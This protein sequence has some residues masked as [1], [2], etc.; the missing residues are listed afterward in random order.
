MAFRVF[1][2]ANILLDFLLKRPEYDPARQLIAWAVEGRIAAFIS[3]SVVHITG[4]W[5]TKVYKSDKAKELL[6]SLLADIRVI[7]IGHVTTINALFSKMV[8]LEDAMQYY[9]AIQHQ[10]DYFVS[11]DKVLQKASIPLLPVCSPEEFLEY[12]Q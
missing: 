11:R 5:L 6:L 9:T 10:I 3:P 12:N 2:D 4:Y 7:D 1:L 8:D